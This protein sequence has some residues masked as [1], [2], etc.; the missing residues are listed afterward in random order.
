[1]VDPRSLAARFA[2]A[3][4]PRAPEIAVDAALDAALLEAIAAARASFPEVVVAEDAFLE[5]LAAK[6]PIEKL[7]GDAASAVRAV[8]APELWLALA[9]ALGDSKAIARLEALYENAIVAAAKRRSGRSAI[10]DEAKQVLFAK[11]FVSDGDGPPKIAEYAGR[12]DLGAFLGVAAARVTLNLVRGEKRRAAATDAAHA[13]PL[14]LDDPEL[15]RIAAR[16]KDDF[17]AALRD[18]ASD[19]TTRERNLLRQ[20]HIDG[21]TMPELAKMYGLH[22]VTIARAIQAAREKLSAGTRRRLEERLRIDVAE[23]ESLFRVVGSNLDLSIQRYLG[24]AS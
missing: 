6:L 20:H 19:L 17:R 5:M 14:P 10:A 15:A 16:Y 11:L 3:A 8:R 7:S 1:M 2:V 4:R 18:A 22:R 23:L 13:A 24:T 21:L 12:G 9:C